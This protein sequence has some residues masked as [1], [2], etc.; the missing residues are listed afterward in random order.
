MDKP[1]IVPEHV[2]AGDIRHCGVCRIPIAYFTPSEVR[3]ERG[4]VVLATWAADPTEYR[5]TEHARKRT[6]RVI[7]DGFTF[8][9]RWS[10]RRPGLH[11]VGPLE[12]KR[13]VRGY[14]R[15]GDWCDDDGPQG[16]TDTDRFRR[17]WKAAWLLVDAYESA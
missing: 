14:Y 1:T 16:R 13:P 4:M 2:L 7:V 8:E 5:C 11:V 3:G 9:G 10:T 17:W 15:D 6:V 12:Y